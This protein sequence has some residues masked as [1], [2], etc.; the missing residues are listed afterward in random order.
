VEGMLDSHGPEWQ[1][2]ARLSEE[3]RLAVCKIQTK[4]TLEKNSLA[5][6]RASVARE[7]EVAVAERERAERLVKAAEFIASDR[8]EQGYS[9]P[10]TWSSGKEHGHGLLSAASRCDNTN[11][12]PPPPMSEEQPTPGVQAQL[13]TEGVRGTGPRMKAPPAKAWRPSSVSQGSA[14]PVRVK[15]PPRRLPEAASGSS[16]P[17]GPSSS[18]SSPASIPGIPVELEH[19][20]AKSAGFSESRQLS[21]EDSDS[22][23]NASNF[24]SHTEQMPAKA[25]PAESPYYRVVPPPPKL[26]PDPESPPLPPAAGSEP[27]DPA[28]ESMVQ[29][30]PLSERTHGEMALPR[31][32]AMATPGRVG[33]GEAASPFV[34]LGKAPASRYK[35]PPS[36]LSQA[37][38]ASFD[39]KAGSETPGTSSSPLLF[40]ASRVKAPPS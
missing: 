37:S 24:A 3:L 40:A 18:A 29:S 38:A 39:K 9:L 17:A 27:P 35:S 11:H 28:E 12:G 30:P 2:L 10:S 13:L 4:L 21:Q 5:A 20:P 33:A 36:V 23:G 31:A 19:A 7:R 1:D 22:N 32:P 26:L 8:K 15:E 25:P 16:A 34:P 14:Q 6:E